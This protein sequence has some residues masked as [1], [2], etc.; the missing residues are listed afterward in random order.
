MPEKP[1]DDMTIDGD[2]FAVVRNGEGAYA[3]WPAGQ[4]VPAGW[5]A[6][7]HEGDADSCSGY[8]DAHW[9]A[10]QSRGG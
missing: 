4:P 8:V 10:M 6:T 7:G 9:T 1:I 2:W 3:I 5:S